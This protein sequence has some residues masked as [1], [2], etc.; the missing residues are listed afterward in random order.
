MTKSFYGRRRMSV[1]H[2]LHHLCVNIRRQYFFS[3][4]LP[5][6]STIFLS[7]FLIIIKPKEHHGQEDITRIPLEVG[8]I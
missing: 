1:L 2:P 7:K 5:S 3:S 6:S 8:K 4:L